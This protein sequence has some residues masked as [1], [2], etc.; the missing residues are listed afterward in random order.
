MG[1]PICLYSFYIFI[2]KIEILYDSIFGFFFFQFF[3]KGEFTKGKIE[4]TNL[5]FSKQKI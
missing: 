1:S 4:N 5:T 3:G 2:W